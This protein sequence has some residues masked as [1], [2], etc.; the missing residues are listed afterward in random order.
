MKSATRVSNRSRVSTFDRLRR[1]NNDFP[2]VYAEDIAAL[3]IN[4]A[5]LGR[6]LLERAAKDEAAK[7]EDHTAERR[8]V[9]K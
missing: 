1:R 3:R 8:M 7:D 5:E 4:I 6:R 9:S 2:G